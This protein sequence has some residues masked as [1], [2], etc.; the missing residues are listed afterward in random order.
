MARKFTGL[1]RHWV[2]VTLA[3]QIASRVREKVA[4][5][6][7]P[8]PQ[9]KI[10]QPLAYDA[11]LLGTRLSSRGDDTSYL[12]SIHYFEEAIRLDP[13]FASAYAELAES[14]AM[15]AFRAEA[16]NEHLQAA[17][18]AAK[19]ALE[20]DPILPEAQIGDA[21]L[22][23][24]WYW[25]WT[26]CSGAFRSAA[27]KYPNSGHV[28]LHYGLCLFVLGRYDE[29]LRYLERAR[30]VDPLSPTLNRTIGRLL[31]MMGRP[32][33]AIDCL[34]KAVD[35]EP[36]DSSGYQFLS[37]AYSKAGRGAESVDA[38]LHGRKLAGDPQSDI[39]ALR[40][41]FHTGGQPA[42]DQQRRKLL[43]AKLEMLQSKP[44]SLSPGPVKLA[45]LYAA[46]GDADM[47]VHYLEQAYSERNPRLTWIKSSVDWEPL[48]NDPRYH[49]LIR[50]MNLPD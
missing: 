4:P 13:N 11:Y 49:D 40:E 44:K 47:A 43:K 24:Y 48:H 23:F 12:K 19:K 50:R 46:I 8:S 45:A 17:I 27:E 16:R 36:E 3:L 5:E 30:L 29:A 10:V 32:G 15:L 18:A 20:L 1:V 34:L 35:M 21:D 33:Q 41:A 22:R 39:D 7:G 42:F 31:G 26:Q 25:D 37:W 6:D 38:Y 9:P 14:H 2:C 28:Q